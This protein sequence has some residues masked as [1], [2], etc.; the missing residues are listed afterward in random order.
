MT[1]KKKN[2]IISLQPKTI[3]DFFSFRCMTF[4]INQTWTSF[5]EGKKKKKVFFT[6]CFLKVHSR[7]LLARTQFSTVGCTIPASTTTFQKLPQ[8]LQNIW[9]VNGEKLST[10]L[11]MMSKEIQ[12]NGGKINFSKKFQNTKVGCVRCVINFRQVSRQIEHGGPTVLKNH[13]KSPIQ[14]CERSELRLHFEWT[15][16]D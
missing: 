9:K 16:V 8:A 5:L 15:K 1:T 14:H 7:T 11:S 13:R 12:K 3:T 10:P 6:H 4:S 2:N